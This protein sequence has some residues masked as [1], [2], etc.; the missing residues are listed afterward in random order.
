MQ[1]QQPDAPVKRTCIRH[2][3]LRSSEDT[4][5]PLNSRSVR[6]RVV[7]FATTLSLTFLLGF[8]GSIFVPP[9][10]QWERATA[11][12]YSNY[13]L[14]D[15]VRW[16]WE[17]NGTLGRTRAQALE[18][19][20]QNYPGSI[21]DDYLRKVN[22]RPNQ[23]QLI[24]ADF[25]VT[26]RND[27]KPRPFDVELLRELVLRHARP[28]DTTLV[29]HLRL[30]DVLL[31]SNAKTVEQLWNESGAGDS[32]IHNLKFYDCIAPQLSNTTFERV[33]FLASNL[34]INLAQFWQ[35]AQLDP[36]SMQYKKIVDEWFAAHFPNAEREWR[37]T[38]LA[39]D[40]D[41]AYMSQARHL[42]PGGGGFGAAAATLVRRSDGRVYEC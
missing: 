1:Q 41:F 10:W 7:A 35:I 6:C 22:E 14:S 42:I 32:Y 37:D 16:N 20:A 40:T 2:V 3:L 8:V 17:E 34:H 12:Y 18:R 5:P 24:A 33:V 29:V 31:N 13:Q 26:R 21:V 15:A 19:Y 38:H 11:Q 9:F 23:S 39:P 36:R 30:A 4:S 25:F 27:S 28:T